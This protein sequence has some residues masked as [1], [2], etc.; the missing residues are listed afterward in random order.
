MG[1]IQCWSAPRLHVDREV[2]GSAD[3][4]AGGKILGLGTS[5]A[6]DTT[7]RRN[8]GKVEKSPDITCQVEKSK[9]TITLALMSVGLE[10]LISMLWLYSARSSSQSGNT[11]TH[12]LFSSIFHSNETRT[13]RSNQV[14]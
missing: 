12:V 5:L 2:S 10:S 4:M 14:Y 8:L 3:F 9:S 13:K 11:Q 1:S 7:V 6:A